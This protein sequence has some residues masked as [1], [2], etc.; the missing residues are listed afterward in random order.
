ML[1]S[2]ALTGSI[3]AGL[4]EAI[5]GA[6]YVDGGYEKARTFVLEIFADLIQQANAKQS[7]GNFKSILQQYAQ[8]NFNVT[9]DYELIDEK[10]PDHDKCFECEVIIAERHFPS[11]WG[12]N[13]KEAEQKAALNAL[14]KLGILKK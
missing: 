8:Q 12:R 14:K 5:I 9:P 11:A 4:L 13:K 3:A 2:R 1:F 7:H 10:G 6:V